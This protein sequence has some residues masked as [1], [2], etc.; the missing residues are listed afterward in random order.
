MI[1][2][3]NVFFLHV[4]AFFFANKYVLFD[5]Q[6]CPLSKQTKNIRKII[7]DIKRTQV[8]QLE[9]QMVPQ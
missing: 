4:Y 2:Q 7:E 8:V 5:V 9:R 3:H 1:S 6:I